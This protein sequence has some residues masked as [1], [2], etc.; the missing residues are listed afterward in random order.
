[1]RLL[2][3]A[4]VVAL[5]VSVPLYLARCVSPV[6]TLGREAC[7]EKPGD[8]PLST[9]KYQGTIQLEQGTFDRRVCACVYF[10]AKGNV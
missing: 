5:I 9:R 6:E 3:T 1:M 10:K 2:R 4:A 8:K 7:G